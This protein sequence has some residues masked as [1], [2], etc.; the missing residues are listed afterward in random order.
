MYA[1]VDHGGV[2]ET[3]KLADARGVGFAHIDK[4]RLS[5]TETEVR[6]VHGDVNGCDVVIFDDM[7]STGGSLMKAAKA[8]KDRG[9]LRVFAVA[10]HGL[11]VNGAMSKLPGSAVDGILVTNSHPQATAAGKLAPGFIHVVGLEPN[12]L[13]PEK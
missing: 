10:T 1:T 3:R 6:E 13:V 9:A 5:G 7:I 8:Y 2:H 12:F 11:F 4:K